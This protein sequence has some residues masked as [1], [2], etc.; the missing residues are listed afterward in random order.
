[1][2]FNP[3]NGI[4]HFHAMN[5]QVFSVKAKMAL[6]IAAKSGSVNEALWESYRKASNLG[7]FHALFMPQFILNFIY[8]VLKK[9]LPYQVKR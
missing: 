4:R 2:S 9:R 8:S 6:K 7:S 5:F 1:M 3:A